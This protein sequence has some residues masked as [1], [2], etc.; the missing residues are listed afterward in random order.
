MFHGDLEYRYINQLGVS[1]P[2]MYKTVAY[3]QVI[4]LVRCKDHFSRS[5][6][7][8]YSIS[9]LSSTVKLLYFGDVF[10]APTD[11]NLPRNFLPTCNY[12]NKQ[13]S[14]PTMLRQVVKTRRSQWT[15]LRA[16]MFISRNHPTCV[17]LQATAPYWVRTTLPSLI[18]FFTNNVA[19]AVKRVIA[20]Y[21]WNLRLSHNTKCC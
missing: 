20:V 5:Q 3:A 18:Y 15:N 9:C 2:I 11:R 8:C 12:E 1:L 7:G 10:D 16:A 6:Q 17:V 19:M 4:N 13:E 14:L 21:L